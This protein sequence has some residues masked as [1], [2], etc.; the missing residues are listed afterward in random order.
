MDQ[1]TFIISFALCITEIEYKLTLP[2]FRDV[3]VRRP[4]HCIIG[5]VRCPNRAILDLEKGFQEDHMLCCD[6]CIKGLQKKRKLAPTLACCCE[7]LVIASGTTQVYR[8]HP[9]H[10]EMTG[11]SWTKVV[12]SLLYSDISNCPATLLFLMHTFRT[13]MENL[14]VR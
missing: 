2:V 7:R 5:G 12:A 10:V 13:A 8:M 4:T 6:I 9:K 14:P 3:K 1:L 11:I